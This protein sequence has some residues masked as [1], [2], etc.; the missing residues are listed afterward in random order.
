MP[1]RTNTFQAVVFMIKN[2]IAA[3]ATVTES[4]ELT[5]LVS[6]E[7]REVDVVI[8]ADVAGHTVTV[9]LECRDHIRP[10][11]V[12]WVEEMHAKHERLPTD[13]LVLV[14]KSGFT[15]GA[16]AKAESYGIETVVPEDL[17]EEQADGIARR[18]R[19]VYTT[20]NLQ[21]VEVIVWVSATD[22]EEG[23]VV[24]TLPDND[25]FTESGELIGPMMTVVQALMQAAQARFGEM[26]FEAPEDTQGFEVL[27]DPAI[28][29]VGDPPTPHELYLQKINPEL[30]LRLVERIKV[31]GTARIMRTEFPLRRGQ[32]QG[33][34]YSW[35][36]A[37]V[38]G[39]PTT[40]VTTMGPGGSTTVS[41]RA[42]SG[43]LLEG[44]RLPPQEQSQEAGG[45]SNQS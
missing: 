14:S 28:I 31:K 32:L 16:L 43:N 11:T 2:H 23:E 18:A 25:V 8:E 24:T 15:A 10:Q 29:Y 45:V 3:N 41:L 38:E 19:M 36:E 6:G 5:D 7:R 27:A 33:T 9:S 21:A 44:L 40:V 13:R 30:H 20:L 35:G 34:I 4:K 12:S 26:I 1:R 17:T 39:M 37:T 42:L 22:T